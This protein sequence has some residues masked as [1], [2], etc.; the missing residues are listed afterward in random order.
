V[1]LDVFEKDEE[2]EQSTKATEPSKKDKKKISDVWAGD[3]DSD[4]EATPIEPVK[5]PAK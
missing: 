1:V 2:D 5:K 3:S 4:G